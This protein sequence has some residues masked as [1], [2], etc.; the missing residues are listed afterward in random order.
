MGAGGGGQCEAHRRAGRAAVSGR[1]K[2]AAAMARLSLRPVI[3]GVA[4]CL[5]LSVTTTVPANAAVPSIIAFSPTQGAAGAV[6]TISGAGFS[7]AIAVRFGG[8]PD[9]TFIVDSDTQITARVPSSAVSG[10]IA[11]KNLEGM[12]QSTTEFTVIRANWP[13]LG[14]TPRRLGDNPSEIMLNSS[15]VSNLVPMWTTSTGDSVL[16]QPAVVGSRVYVGIGGRF[17]T[18]KMEALN[19]RTGAVLWSTELLEQNHASPAAAGAMIYTSSSTKVVA[20]NTGD[21]SFAWSTDVG[22]MVLSPPAVANG[23]VYV[24]GGCD[25]CPGEVNALNASTGEI[26]WTATTGQI[27]SSAPAVASDTVYVGSFDG[28]VYAF[29]AADGATKWVRATGAS[30]RSSPVVA[31]GTVYAGSDDGK[32]YGLNATTGSIRWSFVTGNYASSPAVVGGVVYAGSAD[33]KMYALSTNNGAV[34]WAT[35]LG[36]PV[37]SSPAVANGI[38]YATA[39]GANAGDDK[40]RVVALDATTG[41]LLWSAV[42]GGAFVSS[43]PTIANG[44]VFVGSSAHFDAADDGVVAYG[45]AAPTFELPFAC[46]ETWRG[47]TYENHASK[48]G[49]NSFYPLDL[50][51][52]NGD[53]WEY[54]HPV[55]ASAAGTVV[56]AVRDDASGYG[57]YVEIDH[58]GGWT[59]L[60]AHLSTIAVTVGQAVAEGD[61]VG[62]V[63]NTPAVPVHLHYEQAHNG[64][65]RP[66]TFGGSPFVYSFVFNGRK[67]TSANNC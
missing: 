48:Y 56:N 53:V 41:S 15:T 14:R 55:V 5:M 31:G 39:G 29:N 46:G 36:A 47:A 11:V 65:L 23:V 42:L 61:V 62:G 21:G 19:A 16:G 54:G 18:G 35:A 60:Y 6:V 8:A 20:L 67:V 10:R 32:I 52:D 28:K 45:L 38:V 49:T 4:V 2:D 40:S 50:N 63:G 66:V 37:A 58:G 30:V 1:W 27:V 26:L 17:F 33:G 44:T 59:T 3:V 22:E 12:Q 13:Q 25:S 24:G 51:N 34:K 64:K 7:R 43:S 57:N 9:S